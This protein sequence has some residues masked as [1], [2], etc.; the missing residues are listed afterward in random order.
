MSKKQEIEIKNAN[1]ESTQVHYTEFH[2]IEFQFSKNA[3]INTDKN[4]L[5]IEDNDIYELI[6]EVEIIKLVSLRNFDI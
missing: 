1:I 4:Y 6:L 5:E 2:D 3:N